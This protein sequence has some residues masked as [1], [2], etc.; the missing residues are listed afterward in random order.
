LVAAPAAHRTLLHRYGAGD[1]ID[2]TGKLRQEAIADVLEY[3]TT[4][5][6]DRWVN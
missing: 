4:V 2:H 1:G 5:L 6:A 3:S